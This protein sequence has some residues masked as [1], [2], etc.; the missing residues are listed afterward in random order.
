MAE[1]IDET[2]VIAWVDGELGP[3]E[4]ARV[5]QAVAADPALRDLAEAHRAM[6]ARFAAAFGPIADDP[7][8]LP[9]AEVVSFGEARAKRMRRLWVPGAIAASLVAGL[10]IGQLDRP[11]GVRDRA[12]ALA[13]APPLAHALDTQL[14]GA[15]GPVRVTLSFRAQDGAYCRSFNARHLDGVACRTSDGW[16]LRYAAPGSAQGGE[17]AQAGNDPARASAIAAMIAGEPL[18]A[19]AER[20][21]RDRSWR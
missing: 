2:M 3:A 19:A 17:Y 18:D 21:A 6:R 7:V 8:A 16:T 9:S 11:V 14:S 13:L 12:D 15:A 10:L 20:A 5:E 4:A 1:P